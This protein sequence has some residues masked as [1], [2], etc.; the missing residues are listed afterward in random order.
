MARSRTTIGIVTPK[1]GNSGKAQ[2]TTVVR[3]GKLKRSAVRKPKVNLNNTYGI[4][5]RSG[6]SDRADTPDA[7]TMGKPRNKTYKRAKRSIKG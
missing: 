4:I 1:G 2:R 7:I 3:T 6:T 5:G